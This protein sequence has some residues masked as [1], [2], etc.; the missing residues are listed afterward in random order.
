MHLISLL[1][2]SLIFLFWIL[3]G[4][5]I[6]RGALRLPHLEN[7]EP[8]S[9]CPSISLIFAARDEQE[10]LPQALATLAE[11]DYPALEIIAVNDRSSDATGA[12]LTEAAKRNARLQVVNVES[13][14]EGW[15]GKPHALQ[16]GYEGSAGEW[17]LFTDA[18]VRFTP[19]SLPRAM[20]MA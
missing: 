12:I 14:P 18:D 19:D 2:F 13:L 5:R 4:L 3:Q 9:S 10:K 6:G 17:L 7:H 8:C 15:L 16:K 20:G 11:I 1:L